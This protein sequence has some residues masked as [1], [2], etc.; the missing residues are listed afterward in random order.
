MK[1]NYAELSLEIQAIGFLVQA[2]PVYTSQ[3]GDPT[4]GSH[5]V[6][7]GYLGDRLIEI[8]NEIESMGLENK[9]NASQPEA[10]Q[11]G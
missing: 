7:G 1:K 5:I 3:C 11:E 2:I 8:A 10:E 9:F 6:A 4:D